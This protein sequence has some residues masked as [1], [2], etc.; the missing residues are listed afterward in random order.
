MARHDLEREVD[1]I[2]EV[3][4]LNGYD[5]IPV[6][7]PVS[8]VVRRIRD[9]RQQLVK[10]VRDHFVGAG[11]S[12]IVNYSFVSPDAWNK[13]GLAAE[14]KRC[15]TVK[16]LNPLTEEQSV[17]RTSLLP[18]MLETLAR[19]LS[20]RSYDLKLFELRPVFNVI[21][22]AVQPEELMRLCAAITGRKEIE[23][24]AQS[25]DEVDFYDLKGTVEDLCSQLN[26][27]QVRVEADA[28]EPY[29][30]PGKSCRLYQDK[31][32]I[33]VMG[34]LHPQI[35]ENYAID[36][37]VYVVDLDVA[38]LQGVKRQVKQFKPISRFPDC[39]RDSA[40]LF[41][42][43]VCAQQV[44]DALAKIKIKN[45]DD[46]TLFDMYSGKGVPEGKKSLAIRA[47]YRSLEKT[48]TDDEI[49]SM[50]IKIV[51]ALQKNLGAEIR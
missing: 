11:F 19:N 5:N 15:Q 36:Q 47:R 45:L 34:E 27:G 2:E 39:Y 30:H 17:M 32:F 25:D 44:F 33:G 31:I 3:A 49:N 37:I 9:D 1:L 20:Y 7:M 6:T 18:G 38:A 10:K 42:A 4:R 41:D 13:I 43:E 21:A 51:K 26:M 23:G 24:W 29:L 48:L 40:F 12:E 8:R 22:D 46:V 16:I 35:Q 14:D 50:H 28:Q